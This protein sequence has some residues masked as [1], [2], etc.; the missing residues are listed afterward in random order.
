M[1]M[2]VWNIHWIVAS[3]KKK[4]RIIVYNKMK[5]NKLVLLNQ[6]NWQNRKDRKKKQI[7]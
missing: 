7:S 3:K 5:G 4:E 1:N 6:I 2:A